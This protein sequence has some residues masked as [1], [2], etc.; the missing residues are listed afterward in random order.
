MPLF[1]FVSDLHGSIE[2]YRKLFHLILK[3]KPEAVFL[4]GDLL[5]AGLIPESIRGDS[6]YDF[7]RDFLGTGFSKLRIQLGGKYPGVFVI[8]G[9]DDPRIQEVAVKELEYQGLLEYLQFRSAQFQTYS[10]FGYSYVPP[11]P[12]LLKDWERYDVSRYLE[13]GDVSPEE[14]YRSVAITASEKRYSTIKN[15][16]QELVGDKD[17]LRAIFLFH[18]PPYGS[19]LDI[20]NS[21]S[22]LFEGVARDRHQGSIAVRD[23]IRER[24][25]LI[26]LHGHI[27]ESHRH[28]GRWLEISGR[29]AMM[30]A[31]YDGPELA[32][33]RFDPESPEKATRD[34]I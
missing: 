34:I 12:F 23:F 29:T 26:T 30:S 13:P 33:V 2:R 20:I 18:T 25:P 28:S 6:S 27:H 24:Q 4:G 10:L 15:D 14:G 5:P 7:V 32:L 17:M 8:L 3:E 16:L 21:S 1:Y 9:N 31:A 19:S 22:R 11:T